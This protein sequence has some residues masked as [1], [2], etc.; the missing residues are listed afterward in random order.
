ML[1]RHNLLNLRLEYTRCKVPRI[2]MDKESE[3]LKR[4]KEEERKERERK[5]EILK[6]KKQRKE[7]KN[8]LK[9]CNDLTEGM[10][11]T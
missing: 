9:A 3:T 5:E 4:L 10:A 6:L 7:D 1:K 11:R 2:Q 8:T